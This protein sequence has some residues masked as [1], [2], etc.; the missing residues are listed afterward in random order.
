MR[1]R[2]MKRMIEEYLSTKKHSDYNNLDKLLELYFSGYIN[3][4]LSKYDKV[5]IMCTIN[6]FHK[7]L[8]IQCNYYNIHIVIDF[9][10]DKYN[11]VIYY[12]GI[13]ANNLDKLIVDYEYAAD[14]NIEKLIEEIDEKVKKHPKLNN[15]PSSYKRR[16]IY[17]LIA[18]ICLCISFLVLVGVG[19]YCIVTN[20]SIKANALWELIFIIIPLLAWFIFD[21]KSKRM[22]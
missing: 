19:L 16:K 8:H 9:F 15:T 13:S 20:S 3:E 22:K 10:E 4:L 11:A 7:A 2:N 14:F 12:S 21:I 18:W 5:K 6:K 17:S 1:I